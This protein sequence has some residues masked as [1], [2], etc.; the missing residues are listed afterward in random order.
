MVEARRVW[1]V[2]HG[3]SESNAGLPTN[4]PAAS[5]LTPLGR[6]QAERVAAMFTDPPALIVSSPFVRARQTAR[7]TA[8][9]FP[10]TPYEEWPVEE[11]TYLGM[12]HSPGTTA[13][14]R[15]PFVE[16][17]WDRCDPA[18]AGG[19]DGESFQGLIERV[20]AFLDRAA[21][22]PPDGPIAVFTHG[23]FMK[24]VMWSLLTGVTDPTAAD[25]RRF[26]DFNGSCVVP[27]GAV[28]ELWRPNGPYGWRVIAGATTHLADTF[29]VPGTAPSHLD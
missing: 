23:I 7:P 21:S 27:N 2:R 14:Q 28:V 29:T 20:R 18:Y 4:G 1:M 19:G 13:K 26:R 10:E 25:M 17:Y 8:E 24:A 15:Q 22:R 5:P 16:D 12:L 11:F 6:E 9:R 3:Q